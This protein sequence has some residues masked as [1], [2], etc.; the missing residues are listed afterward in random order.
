[1][2]L[3]SKLYPLQKHLSSIGKYIIAGMV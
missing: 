2:F 3:C 1:L